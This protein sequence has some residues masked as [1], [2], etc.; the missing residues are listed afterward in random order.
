MKKLDKVDMALG[1]ILPA[2]TSRAPSQPVT[3]SITLL[4]LFSVDV[5]SPLDPSSLPLLRS[6]HLSHQMCRSIQQLLP[7]LDSLHLLAAPSIEDYNLSIQESTSMTSLSIYDGHILTLDDASKTVI[8]QQIE[9]FRLQVEQHDRSTN[10]TLTTIIAGSKVMKKV[11]LE[12]I[13][14]GVEDQD[15]PKHLETLTV[16][17]AACKKKE[18]EL[19]KEGFDVGNGKVDLEK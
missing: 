4:S 9:E 7:R 5:P 18:I 2:S 3:L 14:L 16:V 12:G 6:L 17:K 10:S 1:S 8:Q 11:I 13:Y 15:K 19:W